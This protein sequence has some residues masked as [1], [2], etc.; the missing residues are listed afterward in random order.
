MTVQAV[1]TVGTVG[2]LVGGRQLP[3]IMASKRVSLALL[4]LI[5]LVGAY[6]AGAQSV[7]AIYLDTPAAASSSSTTPAT[8]AGVGTR[9]WTAKAPT[10]SSRQ[11][12]FIRLVLGSARRASEQTGWPVALILAQWA[13]EHNWILPDVYVRDG[14]NFGHAIP[15]DTPEG[16]CFGYGV[17]NGFCNAPD[18]AAGLRIWVHVAK[19]PYYAAVAPAAAKGGVY[20]AATALGESPWAESHY[21][22]ANGNPGGALAAIISQ[23]HLEQY[24]K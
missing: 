18:Q 6:I 14:F 5:V 11:D 17:V 4:A 10:G 9:H 24:D 16:V 13:N 19:L 12:V 21:A 15:F 3:P 8:G 22:D 20:S 1:G 7:K 2:N 23:W